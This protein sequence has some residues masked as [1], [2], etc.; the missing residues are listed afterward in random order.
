M[1]LTKYSNYMKEIIELTKKMVEFESTDGNYFEQ[2]KCAEFIKN[3]LSQHGYVKVIEH[4]KVFSIIATYKPTKTPELF[5]TG[6]F[7]VVPAEKE[8]FKPKIKGNNLYGRGALDMKIGLAISMVLFKEFAKQK[9]DFGLIFT[10]DEEIG[11][12]NGIG[13][14]VTQG[15][16]PKFALSPESYN[17]NNPKDINIIV[18]EK[19][20]TW[21]R[22]ISY[23]KSA[24]AS[25][26]WEGENAIEKAID[27]FIRFKKNFSE[28][29]KNNRWKTTMNL[30][31]IK[32]GNA[33]NQV[34]D[35][36][37]LW[38]DIR[39][40]EDLSDKYIIKQ[41]KKEFDEVDVIESEPMLMND[42]NNQYI[43]A[44][45]KASEKVCD[46]KVFLV[47]YPGASD[48]RY[49]NSELGV[50][51]VDFGT[52]G[53]NIHGPNEYANLYTAEKIYQALKIFIENEISK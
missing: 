24:H 23:G 12:A 17:G 51:A 50:P 16:K 35:K 8:Q 15:Y 14:I 31:I 45:K 41:A 2:K 38:V 29:T 19:G 27:A 7:D 28:T 46:G 49:F 33:Q 4:N 6:H 30:S 26:L 9:P 22:L 10:S 36:V 1:K 3:Y 13:Y 20:V 5:I 11:G 42:S 21:L 39:R 44:L 43:Q 37:E 48:V 32:G 52:I 18:K 47:D 53:D 40:T 25:R 34:P